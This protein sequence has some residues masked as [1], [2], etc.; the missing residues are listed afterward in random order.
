MFCEDFSNKI[1]EIL[2][3]DYFS[4]KNWVLEFGHW[5]TSCFHSENSFNIRNVLGS[6]AEQQPLQ[7]LKSVLKI[8]FLKIAFFPTKGSS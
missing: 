5:S 1:S 3:H 2:P 7:P 6:R 8:D 4:L